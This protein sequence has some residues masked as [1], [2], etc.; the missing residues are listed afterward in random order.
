M[1]EG[2]RKGALKLVCCTSP[3][4]VYRDWRGFLSVIEQKKVNARTLQDNKEN[5]PERRTALVARELA[6]YNVDIASL[7]ETRFANG[8]H[9][10]EL[11]GGYA[12]FWSD[13]NS[14]ER[15][16]TGV[17]FVI[18][19]HLGRKFITPTPPSAADWK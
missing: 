2:T 16:E 8:W 1:G 19:S 10:A 13:R 6:R 17:G 12:F 4:P 9:L 5:R 18:K 11:N 15:R 14:S 3:W 7:S